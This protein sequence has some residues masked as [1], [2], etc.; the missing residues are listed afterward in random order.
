VEGG[1]A[2]K[3]FKRAVNKIFVKFPIKEKD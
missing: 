1:G 3:F 2:K